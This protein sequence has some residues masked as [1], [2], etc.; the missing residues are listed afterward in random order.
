[1]NVELATQ[2]IQKKEANMELNFS[3]ISREDCLNFLSA[4]HYRDSLP[5]NIKCLGCFTDEQLV[6]TVSIY[7]ASW[8]QTEIRYL[9]VDKNYRNKGIGTKLVEKAIE[10]VTT[11]VIATTVIKNNLKSMHIFKKF[12]FQGVLEF[13]N[14]ETLNEVL[15]MIRKR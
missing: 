13:I 14:P 6:G 15:L 4:E 1:M 5:S 3:E 8:F 12:G 7:K 11:P 9:Y 2:K 10:I